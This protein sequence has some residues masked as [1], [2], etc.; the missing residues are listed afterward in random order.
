M[1]RMM[2]LAAT[3]LIGLGGA[4]A[5]WAA[6]LYVSAA[7][8]NDA[9]AGTQA[10]PLRTVQ[11]AINAAVTGDEIRVA[12][13][14]YRQNLRVEAKT[15]VLRGGYAADWTRNVA[16]NVTTLQSPGDNAVINLLE[17]DSTVDGFRITG[18][19]GS[20]EEAPYGFHGGG[21]YCRNGSPTITA[22][23]IESNDVTRADSASDYNFGGGI[24]VIDGRNATITDNVV[25]GNS[26]GRGAGIAVVGQSALIRGN[27]VEENTAVGDHGGGMFIA[28]VDAV[29]TQNVI[30]GNE[31][32]RELGYGWGG[33]LIFFGLGNRAEL[34]FN[35]LYENYAA[36]YGAAEFIDEGASVTIHHEL[37][38]NN[39]SKDGCE[40]VSAIAV[41]G[42]A[43][44][45]SRA[46]ISFCTVA[47][48]VCPDSTR[49]NGL[50]VEGV[51]TVTVTNS[52]FW[53]NGGD[54]FA[55]TDDSTLEVSFTCSEE[56][57]AGSGNINVDPRFVDAAAADFRLSSG[58][59]CIDAGDPAT[60]S[61]GDGRVD[62][63]RFGFGS[64]TGPV[65]V[66]DVDQN[67]TDDLPVDDSTERDDPN[68]PDDANQPHDPNGGPDELDPNVIS[69]LL[70][71]SGLCPASAAML[72]S[73]S[74]VGVRR[75]RTEAR[76]CSKRRM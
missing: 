75:S 56:G 55:V 20:T 14:T 2:T 61:E 43:D 10:S 35:T 39:V 53:N 65:I 48:N 23:T 62:M 58:S 15:L 74:L 21:I 46:T 73:L 64:V 19:T 38:Y 45:G 32:G 29:V 60:A 71:G 76:P 44:G 1:K 33:G 52:I 47:G 49:G 59:P 54:D 37:I 30:R 51:S 57:F 31:V 24:Y 13:G 50:Q 63:G 3:S 16:A 12:A 28:V 9:N 34:S 4:N 68:V 8:G 40:A 17:S 27:T 69:E 5:A 22:N 26:A 41:D 36:A 18:G 6:E 42:G 25:R 67:Q 72:F 11:A 66:D 70:S 7:S